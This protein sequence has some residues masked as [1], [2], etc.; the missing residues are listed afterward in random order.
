M[1]VAISGMSAG[2]RAEA[3]AAREGRATPSRKTRG[4]R[5]EDALDDGV[6]RVERK[7]VCAGREI[8]GWGFGGLCGF[9]ARVRANAL[10]NG[11][12]ICAEG[13][14]T[15][16]PG[17]RGRAGRADVRRMKVA[18]GCAQRDRGAAG[19][20]EAD[21]TCAN[22]G[23]VIWRRR[24][25][26]R[27]ETRDQDNVTRR[28]GRRDRRGRGVARS[29]ATGEAT[30]GRR[31]RSRLSQGATTVRGKRRSASAKT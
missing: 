20:V 6:E 19:I 13:R 23:L 11:W 17:D 29:G 15:L 4:G 14:G 27:Q 31:G 18:V 3:L 22:Q 26:G 7:V 2:Q 1:A 8:I 10:K 24:A 5:T 16:T 21:E 9:A 12:R 25:A 30:S 28:D